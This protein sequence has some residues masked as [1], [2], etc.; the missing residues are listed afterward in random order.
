MRKSLVFWICFITSLSAVS[1]IAMDTQTRA[2]SDNYESYEDVYEALKRAGIESSNL[3]I[4][5]DF[6]KS[7]MT[8]GNKTYVP[9]MAKYPDG[10]CFENLHKSDLRWLNPYQQVISI[11]AKTLDKFDEDKIY[12]AFG[13]G[14]VKTKATGV[15][16]ITNTT[17]YC[18]G[19]DQV[20]VA[21]QNTANNVQMSGP[22]SFEPMI[23]KAMEIVYEAKASYHILVIITDGDISKGYE[24]SNIAALKKASLFPLSIIVVGVGDGPFDQMEDF[25]DQVEGR[26]F[27]N[28]QFINFTGLMEK[29]STSL[30]KMEVQFALNATME[31]PEQYKLIK[32]K[33]IMGNEYA[34]EVLSKV[35]NDDG[36]NRKT[37]K[38]IN[39]F[40]K[41]PFESSDSKKARKSSWW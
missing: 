20:F 2:I 1:I 17:N 35:I 37:K 13:F 33:N 24:L 22:T 11:M 10:E 40:M 14:D 23:E 9:Q 7:N 31:I 8:Q 30:K 28:L 41:K 21:Y 18:Q 29:N 36:K 34:Q 39:K 26:L 3:I 12:P 4:G 6:T 25:D 38:Y 15:F 16:N 5:I 27:D 32:E 19:L